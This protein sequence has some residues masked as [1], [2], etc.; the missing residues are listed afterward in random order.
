MEIGWKE[1]EEL[2]IPLVSSGAKLHHG[3]ALVVSEAGLNLN[4]N[5]H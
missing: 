5:T 1:E 2:L 3:I 4:A